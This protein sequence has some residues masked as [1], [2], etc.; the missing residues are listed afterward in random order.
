MA[1]GW[2]MAY[3]SLCLCGGGSGGVEVADVLQTNS[4]LNSNS[5]IAIAKLGSLT[6]SSQE[7]AWLSMSLSKF[8]DLSPFSPR[9]ESELLCSN[10]R[11]M[12]TDFCHDNDTTRRGEAGRMA[13]PGLL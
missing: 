7:Q 3:Y 6:H 1:Y 12:E 2:L 4:E 9:L 5:S 10:T 8:I 11:R 13:W